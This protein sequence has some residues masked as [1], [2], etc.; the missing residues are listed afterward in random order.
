M[1][2]LG[3][4]RRGSRYA[5]RFDAYY[6]IG[7]FRFRCQIL[8]IGP[9]GVKVRFDQRVPTGQVVA[10]EAAEANVL[11]GERV[12]GRVIWSGREEGGV[13]FEREPQC[14]KKA[15][16]WFRPPADETGRVPVEVNPGCRK[17]CPRFE[18]GDLYLY[19]PRRF[20]EDEPIRVRFGPFNDLSVIELAGRAH[21]VRLAVPSDEGIIG[22]D[23]VCRVHLEPLQPATTLELA[24]YRHYLS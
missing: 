24:R 15:P 4:R 1:F 17:V 13:A 8:D 11:G 19:A 22:G 23:W 12:P 18:N 21:D 14:F 5:C 16:A 2:S 6:Y 9:L 7:D 10:I 20:F 3:E